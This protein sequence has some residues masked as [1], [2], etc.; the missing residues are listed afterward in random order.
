[1][2]KIKLSGI[3]KIQHIDGKMYVGSAINID[4]RWKL[5]LAQLHSN[6]HHSILL[7]RA[8]N[9]Y[10]EV[11]FKFE[12]LEIVDNPTKELL[13]EREQF[14]M[15]YY[16][17]YDPEKGYNVAIKAGTNL[18]IK[19]S[20][21]ARLKLSLARKGCV[22]WNKDSWKD[23]VS[24]E[25]LVAYYQAGNS[26]GDCKMKFHISLDSIRL[27]LRRNNVMRSPLEGRR[28]EKFRNKIRMTVIGK[29]SPRKGIKTEKISWNNGIWKSK[30]SEEEIVEFYKLGNS[31]Q[32]C[33]EHFNISV[34]T[35][36]MV[37][38]KHNVVRTPH[39][40]MILEKAQGKRIKAYK[41][42]RNTN[43]IL[44]EA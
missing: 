2:A 26:M 39:E 5:H 23:K 17:C 40:G 32:D 42:W 33:H 43:K 3:Y 44:V 35:I 20:K 30:A 9:K 27:I 15:D 34:D 41:K 19:K 22:A 12:V 7:Q 25:E 11:A 14:W 8:W 10:G 24:E 31:I 4:K 16:Q 28:Q 13:E 21:E 1:M 36:R 18:G 6:R 38:N 37:L 29:P